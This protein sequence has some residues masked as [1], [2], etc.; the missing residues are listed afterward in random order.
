MMSAEQNELITRIGPGTGAGTLLRHYWQPVALVEELQGDRPLRAVRLLGEDL[1]LFR[2]D[3]GRY[4]LLGR[5]CCH[6]GADLAYGRL[7]DGGL[8][9]AFHGWLFDTAGNCLEQPAEPEGST[10]HQ[11]ISHKAYPCAEQSGVIFAYMGAGEP[12]E[13]PG[14]DCF[15]APDEYTFAFK[16]YV[17]CNWL[18]LLEV[19]I[20]PAH[21]S[22]L[23]R[24]EEDED[25]EHGY[26]LQFRDDVADSGLEMTRVMRQ[27]FRPEIRV[28]ETDFGLQLLTLRDLDNQGMHA[29]VTNLLF[30]NAIA[31]P[32]S[33]EMTI[34]QWHVPVDD[35]S[36]YWYAIFTSFDEPIDKARMREQRLELYEL[37]DYH[38][39][40]NKSNNYGYDPKE[41]ATRTFT[42]MG[43]DINVHDQ[44]A[45]ESMGFIQDRTAENLGTTDIAI[46]AYRRM[47]RES[48]ESAENGS[49]AL[50]M[51]EPRVDV[52]EVN[53]VT[54]DAVAPRDEWE[55]SWEVCDKARRDQS[56]WARG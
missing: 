38:P 39:R 48:I 49:D 1:V 47:L 20:D 18:Q 19:G 9:C 3:D 35:V 32:M 23:H 44:W 53:P 41:Q 22:F 42:G 28:E 12:P 55:G 5:R 51:M 7:E 2:D 26:G 40:I 43:D 10:L 34:T 56:T 33:N 14:L 8:R 50:P 52:T 21:A 15:Q 30:P 24:F 37:P 4:G 36:S 54:I 25:S 6:R 17:D 16:G 11:R 46:A 27:S 31:I 45:V 29:R 13:F